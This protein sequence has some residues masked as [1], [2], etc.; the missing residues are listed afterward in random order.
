MVRL[1]AQQGWGEVGE[2]SSHSVCDT[3]SVLCCLESGLRDCP[4]LPS[5]SS[6]LPVFS[7]VTW[8]SNWL[9]HSF[10]QQ[11]LVPVNVRSLQ[12]VGRKEGRELL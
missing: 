9:A 11:T 8:V 6:A 2:S 10:I 4:T 7:E 3:S 5:P 12:S 1:I